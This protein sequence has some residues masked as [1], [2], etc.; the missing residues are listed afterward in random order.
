MHVL[1]EEREKLERS[2]KVSQERME[3]KRKNLDLSDEIDIVS[4][5]D[6]IAN[7]RIAKE[8]K[9]TLYPATSMGSAV[10]TSSGAGAGVGIKSR[11]SGLV[12]QAAYA[13]TAKGTPG[14]QTPNIGLSTCRNN[15]NIV[16]NLI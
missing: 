16:Q 9:H 2:K 3:K 6:Y 11:I 13:H 10:G 14:A 4:Y 15:T 8:Q 1:A 5:N 12:G 7:A